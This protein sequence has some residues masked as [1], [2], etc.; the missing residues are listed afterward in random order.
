MRLLGLLAVVVG[1]AA[2]GC[3]SAVNTNEVSGVVSYKGKPLTGGMIIF[4]SADLKPAVEG[5]TSVSAEILIDG[6][7]AYTLKSLAPGKYVVL[8]ETVPPPP[9]IKNAGP[10]GPGGARMIPPAN[11]K[12]KPGDKPPA[13]I[14]MEKHGPPTGNSL[15]YVP[16][17]IP[18]KY[19]S[20]EKTTLS[21]EVQVGSHKDVN[22]DLAD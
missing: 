13:D 12:S 10:M 15:K 4:Q 19:T 18:D 3:G 14:A 16:V 17:K 11:D 20:P 2:I 9:K 1:L 6:S 5:G 21:Y 8:V 7:G 22:F